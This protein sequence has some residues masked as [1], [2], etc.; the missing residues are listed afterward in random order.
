MLLY[1]EK[2]LLEA[3]KEY[4]K[5]FKHNP[6]LQIPTIEQFRPIYEEFWT[7]YYEQKRTIN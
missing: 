3:Y 5:S 2:Q 6:K 7:D 1:T 4:V